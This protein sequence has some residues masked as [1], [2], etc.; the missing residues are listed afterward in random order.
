M[1]RSLYSIRTFYYIARQSFLNSMVFRAN[2][3]IDVLIDIVF[4]YL[5]IALWS[6]IFMDNPGNNMVSKPEL[7]TYMVLARIAA[8]IDMGFVME[9]QNRILNGEIA[10][11]LTRP[12]SLKFYHFSQEVGSYLNNLLIKVVPI[13]LITNMV[14]DLKWPPSIY[15]TFLFLI[16]LLLSFFLVFNLNFIA[17]I[18]AFWI[19]KLFS[20][21]VFKDQTIRLLSGAIVPLW[22][23]P[24]S[25]LP[26][27]KLLPFSG[28]VFMPINIYLNKTTNEDIITTFIV[29]IFWII[30]TSVIGRYLWNKATKRISING[31]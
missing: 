24:E 21:S 23:F 20:L 6:T 22:F 19:T 5:S 11:D 17:A 12:L 26:W 7:I 28:I 4:I 1:T 31:G 2:Y 10:S 18:M 25:I 29:Q 27:V 14:F 13:F 16:S 15:Q 8:R 3:F 9:V 30:V